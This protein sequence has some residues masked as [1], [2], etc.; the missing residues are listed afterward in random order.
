MEG[1]V[2]RGVTRPTKPMVGDAKINLPILDGQR[3]ELLT[4]QIAGPP[5][6]PSL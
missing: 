6:R 1:L 3:L 4:T 2:A 5:Q